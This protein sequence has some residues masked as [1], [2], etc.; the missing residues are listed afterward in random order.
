MIQTFENIWKRRQTLAIKKFEITNYKS[1]FDL[2]KEINPFLQYSSNNFKDPMITDLREFLEDFLF[3]D[4]VPESMDIKEFTNLKTSIKIASNKNI[5]IV[6]SNN[7]AQPQFTIY[8]EFSTYSI[9]WYKSRGKIDSILNLEY[10]TAINLQE[11]TDILIAL[12]L[13]NP[14]SDQF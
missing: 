7:L 14:Y 8:L 11:I 5:T 1:G 2:S 13:E 9:S 12:N 6:T 3:Y 4:K 10:G